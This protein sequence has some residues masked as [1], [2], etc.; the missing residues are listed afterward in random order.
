MPPYFG[1]IPP[2]TP[3][4][5]D[6]I[7]AFQR[8]LPPKRWHGLDPPLVRCG[9]IG[10]GAGLV[11]AAWTAASLTEEKNAG[12]QMFRSFGVAATMRVVQTLPG[13]LT[14]P[15]SLL[16]GDVL[17]ELGALDAP[18]GPVRNE[19][20]LQGFWDA[21]ASLGAEVFVTDENSGRR[22]LTA[23]TPAGATGNLKKWIWVSGSPRFRPPP[24]PRWASMVECH[25]WFTAPEAESFFA[26]LCPQG[27]V[28]LR[29]P[30]RVRLAQEG[31]AQATCSGLIVNCKETAGFDVLVQW[32]VRGITACACG[33]KGALELTQPQENVWTYD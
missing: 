27:R 19:K 30:E 28:H 11:V 33:K 16:V 25:V 32:P 10:Q 26:F 22:L 6:E 29:L 2:K 3:A 24:L 14:T 15:G 5:R 20:D 18:F 1:G 23:A 17:E 13:A 12:V 7:A 8:H 21:V 4:S 31:R 9:V